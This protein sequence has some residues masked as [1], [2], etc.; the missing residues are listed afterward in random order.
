MI[1][2]PISFPVEKIVHETPTIKTFYLKTALPIVPGEFVMVWL[3]GIDEKPFAVSYLEKNMIGISV[4]KIGPFTEKMFALKK[5]DM[6]GIRGPYG[7][8]FNTEKV[9][10]AVVV[11]A[12]CGNA[13]I[14]MLVEE[15][16]KLKVNVDLVVAG[17]TKNELLFAKRFARM[18]NVKLHLCTDDGSAGSKGFPTAIVQGL[19]KK[20]KYNKLYACGPEIMM[21]K[22]LE[23]CNKEKLEC[24]MSLERYMKC[25]FG[26]CGQCAIDGWLVCKDGPVFNRTQLNKMHEFG[27]FARN[28][29]GKRITLSEY[30]TGKCE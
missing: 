25:G 9:K 14:A 29:S 4:R 7:K 21:L 6:L 13:A 19:V 28:K 11:G 1:D 24:E 18:K 20:K 23:I 22:L 27:K 15:L 16:S 12:G 3:P 30:A 17:R 5:G 2:Y 8:G 26:I 10:N